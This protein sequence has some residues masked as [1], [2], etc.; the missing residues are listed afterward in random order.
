[1]RYKEITPDQFNDYIRNI[2][3]FELEVIDD[4]TGCEADKNY[5]LSPEQIASMKVV[6][7]DEERAIQIEQRFY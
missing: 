2:E 6:I 3:D 7:D 1:M 4:E 5:I